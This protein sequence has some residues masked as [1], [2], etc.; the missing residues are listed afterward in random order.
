M[1]NISGF[2]QKFF[3]L[4]NNKNL[5]V[6]FIIRAIK[7][8]SGVE[9]QKE[10]LDTSEGRVKLN[11]SPAF[12]NQIFMHKDKIESSLRSQKIFLKIY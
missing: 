8:A 9:L 3:N 5:Q 2:F 11:C 1:N 10:M 7:E 6:E 4:E 12:R